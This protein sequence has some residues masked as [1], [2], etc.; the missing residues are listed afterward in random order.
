MVCICRLI[1]FPS[2]PVFPPNK[3]LLQLANTQSVNETS[4]KFWKNKVLLTSSK[5]GTIYAMFLVLELRIF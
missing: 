4:G 1:D 2:R 3:D 5:R